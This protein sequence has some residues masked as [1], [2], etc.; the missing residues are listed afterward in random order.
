MI[1]NKKFVKSYYSYVGTK[2][3]FKY[4]NDYNTL[5]NRLS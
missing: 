4:F 5:E 2:F 1:K 3:I